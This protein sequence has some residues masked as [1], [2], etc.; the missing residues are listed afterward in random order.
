MTRPGGH[1]QFDPGL[2]PERTELAWRRTTIALTVGAAVSL[3]V[4]APAFGSWSVVVG[5][6]GFVLAGTVWVL[7]ARRARAVR[8]NLLTGG[9]PPPAGGILLRL[10]VTVV[11]GSI[12]GLLTAVLGYV[13]R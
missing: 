11:A 9:H 7:A 2:Q 1:E 4:L 3:H 8:R 12:V 6:V 10:C 5:V 13:T